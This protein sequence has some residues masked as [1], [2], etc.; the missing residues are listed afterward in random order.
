[1]QVE[2]WAN[3]LTELGEECSEISVFLPARRGEEWI[4]Q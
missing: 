4:S 3:D 1:M 2:K